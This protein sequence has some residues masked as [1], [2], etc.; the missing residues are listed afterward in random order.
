MVEAKG[1]ICGECGKDSWPC[2]DDPRPDGGFESGNP[3]ARLHKVEN[4][5]ARPLC[6]P[7][8][9]KVME[10]DKEWARP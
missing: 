5:A 8:Y 10:T 7:C 3:L 1:L 2:S 9:T 6:E 4:Y